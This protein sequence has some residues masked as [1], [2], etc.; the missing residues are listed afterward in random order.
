MSP[1]RTGRAQVHFRGV[2]F[3]EAAEG[4]SDET[5]CFRVLWE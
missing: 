4:D 2:E 3:V 5:P 1:A